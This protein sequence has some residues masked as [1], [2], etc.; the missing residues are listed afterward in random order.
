MKKI[1]VVSLLRDKEKLLEA[2]RDLGVVHVAP[3]NPQKAAADDATLTKID[4]LRRATNLLRNYEPTG[5]APGDVD[6]VQAAEEVLQIERD[7]IDRR[8]RLSTLH[9]QLDD[10][11]VW[12]DVRLRQFRD[13]KDAGIDIRFARVEAGQVGEVSA[14]CVQPLDTPAD[15]DSV[16]VAIV[17]R[18]QKPVELPEGA[19]PVA[20]PQRD[21][22]AIQAE[23]EQIDQALQEDTKRLHALANLTGAMEQRLGELQGVAEFTVAERSG[24]EHEALFAIQGWVPADQYDALTEGLKQRGLPAGAEAIDPESDEEPPTLIRYPKWANPIRALLEMLGTSPGY[25]EFDPSPFFMLAMPIFT[26]MLVGDAGYGLIFTVLGAVFYGKIARAGAKPA[27]QLVLVFGIATM[28]WGFITGNFFGVGPDGFIGAGGFL[29][30]VGHGW[31]QLAPLWRPE[32]QAEE[33]RNLIMKVAFVLG[34]IHLISA[35]VVQAIGLL[36]DQRG[37]AEIG[38]VGFIFGM[39]TLVWLMF[40]R[41]NPLLPGMATLWILV[42]SFVLIVLFSSPSRNPVKRLGFGLIGN[43][44]GIPGAFGDML[45]Y[46]RLMAVGLA[47]YYI[48]SAF[49][50]LAMGISQSNLWLL[51]V[52]ILVLLLA[53]ALNVGLCLVAVFAHG[54]RLN[55]LEF[56]TNAGLQWSGRPYA[57]FALKTTAN[58]GER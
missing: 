18:G 24:M 1:F 5:N 16:L 52:T 2:L 11:R 49:N 27:A 7:S 58:E 36:P 19:E 50:D 25:K 42:A 40:F 23:A 34:C 28:I 8:N 22:P 21:R 31:Q 29:E 10:L 15:D 44:M 51:P 55:M 39:F 41:D 54:V 35:H 57:P 56:S 33:G 14:D 4:A 38:W 9:R 6:P 32:E 45:S 26:A 43:L 30:S 17:N 48:A 47:S 53:H 12:G 37:I 13:L 20:L 46:I 3:V